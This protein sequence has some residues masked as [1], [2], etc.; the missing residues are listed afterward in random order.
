KPTRHLL[1]RSTTHGHSHHQHSNHVH[2]SH[3]DTSR[4][5]IPQ[6]THLRSPPRLRIP[7]IQISTV[8][9]LL[10]YVDD[11]IL[12]T[13]T[14][15]F[16]KKIISALSRKFAMSDLGP[17]HY[18]L[19]I[20]VK[21]QAKGI[22]LSQTQYAIKLLERAN[23]SSCNPCKTPVYNPKLNSNADEPVVDPTKNRLLAGSMQYL[24]FNNRTSTML[25]SSVVFTPMTREVSILLRTVHLGLTIISYSIE[26][27]TVYSDA[28]MAGCP[29]SRR[30]TSGYC[31]NL[32]FWSSK[33]QAIVSRSSAEAEYRV[34]ANAI[35]KSCW[36]RSLLKELD[37]VSAFENHQHRL[38]GRVR[39][40]I[41]EIPIG[42]SF[43]HI[44]F[45]IHEYN[46]HNSKY[47]MLKFN[48]IRNISQPNCK[49]TPVH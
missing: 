21:P 47:V 1:D 24:C 20:S 36:L 25:F 34:V 10:V 22:H 48:A 4:A 39:I 43:S 38:R 11:I 3:V 46:T 14:A 40:F 23:M 27:L 5:S 33:C 18:F 26:R 37:P 44:D 12:T 41:V 49:A 2:P 28:D 29:N 30:S 7:S 13:L 35:A 8:A 17:L 15:E 9:Y 31:A 32:V 19:G 16:M 6:P 45:Q 42:S